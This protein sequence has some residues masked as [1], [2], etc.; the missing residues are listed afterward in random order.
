MIVEKVSQLDDHSSWRKYVQ[1]LRELELMEAP[2]SIIMDYKRGVARHCFLAFA[3]LMMDGHLTVMPFHE[4]IACAFEDLAQM[5]Y[6]KLIVSC[7]PRSGKSLLSQLFVSWLIGKEDRNS[8]IIGSYSKGLSGKFHKGILSFCRHREFTKVFPE[9]MGFEADSKYS[10]KGGG[11]MLATSPGSALTGFSAGS[12]SLSSKTVGAMIIDDPLKNSQSAA[13][14]RELESWW[15]EEA[16]T[17]RTNNYCQVIIATRFHVRDLH[18]ILLDADGLYDP[19]LN[20]DGWRWLNIPALCEDPENDPLERSLGASHWPSNPI[21]F[22]E[23]LES[24]KNTMG[25][26]FA[27][28]YQGMPT[29]SDGSL[30]KKAWVHRVKEENLPEMDQIWLACDTAFSESETADESSICVAGCAKVG[31]IQKVFILDIIHGHWD[32]PD[33]LDIVKNTKERYGA[34][35]LVIENAASGQSLIQMLR[36]QSKIPISGMRPI[37]SKTQRF[38]QTLPLFSSNRVLFAE[39]EWLEDFLKELL[40]FPVVPHDDRTDS[41]VWALIYFLLNLDSSNRLS[42]EDAKQ[43]IRVV[44]SNKPRLDREGMIIGGNRGRRPPL[45]Y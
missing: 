7:A 8:H 45:Y 27:A 14:L 3:D 10:F 16:S 43:I 18:G 5:R 13:K 4:L 42:E 24:Q 20:P 35:T 21:F 37:R 41:V 31:G 28:L 25:N 2:Q 23:R 15:G 33:L 1:G 17:R 39:G 12:W 6:S 34:R 29:A 30:C 38:Q 11:E 22:P 26:A 36:K 32:F 19:E 44:R 40:S 9:F